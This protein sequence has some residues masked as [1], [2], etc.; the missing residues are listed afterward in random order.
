MAD[1]KKCPT[2]KLLAKIGRA[3]M[4]IKT[5]ETRNSDGLDFHEVAVREVQAAL[6]AAFVVGLAADPILEQIERSHGKLSLMR[7][8]YHPAS[9]TACRLM[10]QGVSLAVG[11][12]RLTL[13][14]KRW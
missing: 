4:N 10:S 13:S 2:D 5:L 8:L 9:Q 1:N 14:K 3:A 11:G 12:L 7:Q 6:K